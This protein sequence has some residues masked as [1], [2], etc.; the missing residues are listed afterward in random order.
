MLKRNREL[1]TL[2]DGRSRTRFVLWFFAAGS[3]VPVV[4]MILGSLLGP[5]YGDASPGGHGGS[6]LWVLTWVV[7]PT[8][9]LMLDAEHL[10]TIVFMLLFA[11]PLNGLWYGAVGLLVWHLRMK[12]KQLSNRKVTGS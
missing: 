2:H 7:W 10:D 11:A 4:L 1:P 6:I 3:I 9:I 12:L 5:K 8:W